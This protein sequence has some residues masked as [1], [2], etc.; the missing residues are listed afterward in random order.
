[1]KISAVFN[2]PVAGCLL[3]QSY[4]RVDVSVGS[5][6]EFWV[7]KCAI[8]R[9]VVLWSRNFVIAR[10]LARYGLPNHRLQRHRKSKMQVNV[11]HSE[12]NVTHLHR[13]QLGIKNGAN[14]KANEFK[15]MKTC[16]KLECQYL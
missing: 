8:G 10:E 5:A 2:F 4:T 15:R 14:Q 6:Q 11:K 12:N 13:R 7:V 16:V 3:V 9:L 1:M